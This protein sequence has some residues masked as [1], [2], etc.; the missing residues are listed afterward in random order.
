MQ[1]RERGLANTCCGKC[2]N[3]C[4]QLCFHSHSTQLSSSVVTLITLR[5]HAQQGVKR[6]VMVSIMWVC[7]YPKIMPDLNKRLLI[8]MQNASARC[9]D[10]F[11]LL[12]SAEKSWQPV[13]SPQFDQLPVPLDYNIIR[14]R[15]LGIQ[16]SKFMDSAG[17]VGFIQEL[18]WVNLLA[19]DVDSFIDSFRRY[20]QIML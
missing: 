9:S 4:I 20:T 14:R 7:G 6:S 3:I 2:C 19:G 1:Q 15:G 16:S 8:S 12:Q 18:A 10:S 17:D 11:I 5:A 13:R